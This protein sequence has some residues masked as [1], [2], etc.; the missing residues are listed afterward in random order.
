MQLQIV[1]VGR[2]A[3]LLGWE[4]VSRL[5]YGK[6]IGKNII[7]FMHRNFNYFHN[8]THMNNLTH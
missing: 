5:T 4:F 8:S 2:F 3:A 6:S 1:I 7:V